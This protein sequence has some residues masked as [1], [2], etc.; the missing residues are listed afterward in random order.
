MKF[1]HLQ[2]AFKAE[3]L[4]IKGLG[5]LIL[6]II[7][8][9]LLPVLGL[10][11]KIFKES[12]RNYDGV[13]KTVGQDTIEGYVSGFGGFFLL[14]FIIIA[15]T[16]VCQTDHKNNGW[17]FLETQPLSKLSIYTG[18]FLAVFTL[19]LISIVVFILSSVLIGS[20]T[21]MIWPQENLSLAGFWLDTPHFYPSGCD[22]FGCYFAANNAFGDNQRFYLAFYGRFRWICH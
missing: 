19:A 16:R 15:A 3:W 1:E 6:A 21:E 12:T 14:L 10:I 5:L 2:K 18:K 11:I 13:A 17:T 22:E 8:G 4:K 7:F 9:V 20:I